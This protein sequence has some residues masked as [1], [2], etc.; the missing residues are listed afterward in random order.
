MREANAVLAVDRHVAGGNDAS[1]PGWSR[2]ALA[3][4]VAITFALGN[5]IGSCATAGYGQIDAR[6]RAIELAVSRLEVRLFTMEQ[7]LQ[8]IED[9]MQR[10]SAR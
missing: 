9:S 1:A 5:S 4:F 8:R 3:L 6:V 10:I 2:W 7:R